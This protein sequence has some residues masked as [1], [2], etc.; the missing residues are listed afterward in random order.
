MQAR[1]PSD[2]LVAVVPQEGVRALEDPSGQVPGTLPV[3]LFELS[4]VGRMREKDRMPMS[5]WYSLGFGSRALP[6]EG[7][8]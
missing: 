1:S 3:F 7:A 2:I 4:H 5:V 8:A 6:Y